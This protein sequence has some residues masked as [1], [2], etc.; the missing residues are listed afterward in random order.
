MYVR[1]L[2]E[3]TVQC[4]FQDVL[5][6][7]PL[8]ALCQVVLATCAG[9]AE[10]RRMG[11]GPGKLPEFDVVVIDEAAQALEVP[12]EARAQR[13]GRCSLLEYF[14]MLCRAKAL[15]PTAATR[16]LAAFPLQRPCKDQRSSA[17]GFCVHPRRLAAPR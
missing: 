2:Y 7:N 11:A 16:R 4:S 10:A 17:L 3:G 15:R 13:R 14:L 9:A 8:S 12:R 1:A 5:V 6:R